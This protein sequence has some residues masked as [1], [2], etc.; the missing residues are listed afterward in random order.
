M[1]YTSGDIVAIVTI[2]GAVLSGLIGSI[3]YGTSLSRCKEI[4]CCCIHCTREVLTDESLYKRNA[5]D[6]EVA[7]EN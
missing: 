6:L 2:S 5:S 1:E 4:S 7:T 3:L